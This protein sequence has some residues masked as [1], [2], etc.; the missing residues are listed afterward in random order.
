MRDTQRCPTTLR[1][2][3]I[4]RNSNILLLIMPH[5]SNTSE[6]SSRVGCFDTDGRLDTDDFEDMCSGLRTAAAA[7]V[8]VIPVKPTTSS[9]ISLPATPTDTVIILR[10]LT[11]DRM[12]LRMVMVYVS[13]VVC[14]MEEKEDVG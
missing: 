9:T 13:R 5:H 7:A 12:P 6:F 3:V 2:R 4:P 10:S 1:I 11:P 14:F 8:A